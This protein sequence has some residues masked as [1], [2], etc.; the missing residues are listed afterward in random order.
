MSDLEEKDVD[1][2]NSNGF[3]CPT[4]FAVK[5]RLCKMEFKW[6]AGNRTKCVEFLGV[7]NTGTFLGGRVEDSEQP[8]QPFQGPPGQD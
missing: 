4:C 2:F 5:G 7:I 1:E 6:C 3:R 8:F